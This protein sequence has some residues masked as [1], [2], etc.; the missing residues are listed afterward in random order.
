MFPAVYGPACISIE[1]LTNLSSYTWIN[2]STEN[3]L[4]ERTIARLVLSLLKVCD[5]HCSAELVRT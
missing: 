4:P 5:A 2:T 3:A 1:V